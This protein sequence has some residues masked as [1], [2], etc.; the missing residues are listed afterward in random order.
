LRGIRG[1]GK[2]KTYKRRRFCGKTGKLLSSNGLQKKNR[3]K[4]EINRE[5]LV[6]ARNVEGIRGLNGV[7]KRYF[8]GKTEKFEG[9][10]E[11][12]L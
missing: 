2:I 10:R 11:Y 9:F 12:S 7:K 5:K 4:T 3:R 6:V 8:P 1:G